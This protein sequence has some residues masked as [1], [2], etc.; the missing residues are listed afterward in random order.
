MSLLDRAIKERDKLVQQ[1]QRFIADCTS[2]AQAMQAKIDTLQ[3]AI[4]AW[5]P[6]TETI[7]GNLI[8]L[9][10]IEGRQGK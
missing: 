1:R 7:L 8:S 6:A 9:G 2:Q 10:L 4:D 3:A 5:S